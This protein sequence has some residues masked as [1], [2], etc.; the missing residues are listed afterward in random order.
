MNSLFSG[1]FNAYYQVVPLKLRFYEPFCLRS[2]AT[3]ASTVRFHS[4]W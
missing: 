4:S 1:V 3:T 2:H